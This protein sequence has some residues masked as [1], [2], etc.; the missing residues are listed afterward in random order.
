LARLLIIL[1]FLKQ[2][3]QWLN[4][5]REIID[6]MPV[7]VAKFKKNLDILIESQPGLFKYSL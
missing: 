3:L 6:K 1:E 7:E 5:I 2:V 4:N